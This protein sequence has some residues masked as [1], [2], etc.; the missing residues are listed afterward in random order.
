MFHDAGAPF[1]CCLSYSSPDLAG[2]FSPNVV[3]LSQCLSYDACI[4]RASTGLSLCEKRGTC[5]GI[6][7]LCTAASEALPGYFWCPLNPH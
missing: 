5:A 1:V 6:P 2:P 4:S 3:H 7:T